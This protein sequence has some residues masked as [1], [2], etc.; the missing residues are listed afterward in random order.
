MIFKLCE[1]AAPNWRTLN[2]AKLLPDI[3]VSLQFI[4]GEKPEQNAA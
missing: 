4:D 2:E 1:S 3:I